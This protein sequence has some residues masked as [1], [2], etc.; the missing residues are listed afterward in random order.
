MSEYL[1]DMSGNV[2]FVVLKPT[3]INKDIKIK[4]IKIK[5]RFLYVS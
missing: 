5:Y 4:D 3:K 2:L 1:Q